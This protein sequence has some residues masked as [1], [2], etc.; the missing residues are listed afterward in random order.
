MQVDSMDVI[1]SLT[2]T[3]PADLRR[4]RFMRMTKKF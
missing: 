4:A 3:Q 2:Q 1:K